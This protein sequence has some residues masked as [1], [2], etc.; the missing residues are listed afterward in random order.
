MSFSGA[1][2]RY[3]SIK[4]S[5]NFLIIASLKETALR[6]F[7]FILISI[8]FIETVIADEKLKAIDSLYM[9]LDMQ[10]GDT[11]VETMVSLSEAYRLISFDKS[12]KAGEDAITYADEK[13]FQKMRGKILK[14]LGVTAYESGDY[15]LA[16]EYYEKAGIAFEMIDDLGG[17]ATIYHNEG[18]IYR[19]LGDNDKSLEYYKKALALHQQLGDELAAANTNVN[20]GNIYYQ[21]GK[22]EEAFDAQYKSQLVFK[23]ADDSILYAIT[24]YNIANIYWQWD[25]NDKALELLDESLNIYQK[26]NELLRMSQAYYTKGLIYAYDKGDNQKAL[27]MFRISLDLREKIGN[28][29]GTANVIINIANVWM[30]QERYDEAFEFYNRGL[31]IHT[32]LGY[33]DG[34]LMAYYYMGLAHQKMGSY[35]QSNLLFDQCE[36]KALE[37]KISQ[38][39]DL[40]AEGRLKNYAAL[41]DFENFLVQFKRFSNARDTIAEQYHSLKT[42]AA[43]NKFKIEQL[44]EEVGRISAVNRQQE[45]R[46]QFFQFSFSALLTLFFVSLLFWVYQKKVKN[47]HFKSKRKPVEKNSPARP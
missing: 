18:L 31:R 6:S 10:Q 15:D 17:K 1:L 20:I 32:T 9:L 37:F 45:K 13:G 38:Y 2:F 30:E 35:Q 33:V 8:F 46:I 28:P 36:N 22:L 25:Q 34:I 12:L 11:R 14:S 43:N 21:K 23:K 27:E 3:F 5:G 47:L 24:T 7:F 39:E 16:L 41:G 44:L 29:Q 4:L 26:F 42:S 40:I 19:M